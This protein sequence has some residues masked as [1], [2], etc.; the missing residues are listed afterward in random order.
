MTKLELIRRMSGKLIYKLENI[1]R[2]ERYLAERANDSESVVSDNQIDVHHQPDVIEEQQAIRPIAEEVR[3]PSIPPGY[4]ERKFGWVAQYLHGSFAYDVDRQAQAKAGSGVFVSQN[5]STENQGS[6]PKGY[7]TTSKPVV[8]STLCNNVN[9]THGS[10]SMFTS[11]R[12]RQ[13]YSMPRTTTSATYTT[14]PIFHS[15]SQPSYQQ[16]RTYG[17]PSGLQN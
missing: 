14:P 16:P 2:I 4:A 6:V 3:D 17:F 10:S 9:S 1:G 5:Q 12:S 7:K 11:Y 15:W 13:S 8:T